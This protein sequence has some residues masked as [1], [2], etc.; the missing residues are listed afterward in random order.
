MAPPAT[1]KKASGPSV[2]DVLEL[3]ANQQIANLPNKPL[4]FKSSADVIQQVINRTGTNIIASTNRS[5]TTT[6]LIQGA[7]ADVARARKE[8]VAGLVVKVN[9]KKKDWNIS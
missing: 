6:F 3:P 4:G 8:L 7:P 2:T 5:G 9:L 1:G